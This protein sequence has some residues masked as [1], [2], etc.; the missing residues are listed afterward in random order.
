MTS[1]AARR[2]S[3]VGILSDAA[4]LLAAVLFIP[5]AILAIGMPI[6][7]V[8]AALLWLARLARAAL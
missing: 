7:L 5:F 2:F 8:I 6:A 4:H 1:V 3:V